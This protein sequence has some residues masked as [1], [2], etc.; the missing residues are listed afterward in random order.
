MSSNGFNFEQQ[1]NKFIFQKRETEREE[2]ESK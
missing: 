2:N 1:M